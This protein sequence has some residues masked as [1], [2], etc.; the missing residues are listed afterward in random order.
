MVEAV[1]TSETSVYYE[2]TQRYVLEGCH[3]LTNLN[4][5]FGFVAV[6]NESLEAGMWKF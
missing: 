5:A 4:L 6:S 3:L 2:T 1:H